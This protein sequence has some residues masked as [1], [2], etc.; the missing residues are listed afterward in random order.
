VV[1]GSY[2]VLAMDWLR[3]F[4][5]AEAS[6]MGQGVGQQ[7]HTRAVQSE[8]WW[9]SVTA[10]GAG[11]RVIAAFFGLYAP[12]ALTSHVSV[13]SHDFKRFER[14]TKLATSSI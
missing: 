8:K 14:F 7:R 9:D 12:Y 3:V 10:Y 4:G 5:N 11:M 13:F 1:V 2:P 6:R